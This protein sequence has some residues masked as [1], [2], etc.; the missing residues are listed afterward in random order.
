MVLLARVGILVNCVPLRLCSSS[1]CSL[2]PH[3]Q[4]TLGPHM[5]F[6]SVP[7]AMQVA[8]PSQLPEAAP[9]IPQ[10]CESGVP[11]G[12]MCAR[13]RVHVE[14]VNVVAQHCIRLGGL[15]ASVVEAAA[16]GL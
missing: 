14:E 12:I 11:G 7:P 5:L 1:S 10:I 8:D 16:L 2:F 6:G 4:Q 15:Q 9:I 3:T 13:A